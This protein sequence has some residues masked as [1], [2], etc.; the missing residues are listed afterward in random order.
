MRTPDDYAFNLPYLIA[1]AAHSV[2]PTHWQDLEVRQDPRIREFIQ[3]VEFGLI[4]DERDFGLAKLED[5][6]TFQMRIEL[7]AKGRTF[8]EKIPYVKGSPEPEEFGNTDEEIIRKF[9]DNVSR[10]LPFGKANEV[11]KRLLELE[12]LQNVAE[13]MEKGKLTFY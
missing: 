6:R 12:K 5:P 1:C 13:V 10:T 9:T 11:A 3:R 7:V 4:I 2:N 8:K